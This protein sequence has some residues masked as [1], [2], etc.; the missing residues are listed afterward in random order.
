MATAARRGEYPKPSLDAYPAHLHI[1]VAEVLRGQ[2]AGRK[3]MDAGLTA[4][5]AAGAPGIHLNTTSY[6]AAA[7]AMYAKMG[8]ELLGSKPTRL[9][10]P[11]LPGVAIEN[12]VYGRML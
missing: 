6:N 11:W 12:Q 4:I 3:L 7:V 9:W 10:E 2:G 5:A 1:N 8:F